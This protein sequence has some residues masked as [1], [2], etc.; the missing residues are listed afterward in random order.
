MGTQTRKKRE[1]E[2]RE[3]NILAVARESLIASGY[4]GLN[5]DAIASEL[6]YSK[7]TIYNHFNCKEEIII[8]LA[9]ETMEKRWEMFQRAAAYSG[10]PRERIAAVGVAAELFVRLYPSHFEVEQLI[11]A[12]SIWEK[13]SETRRQTMF[14][15]ES[16][17]MG[18]LAGVVRDGISQ[19]HLSLPDD[20]QPEDLVFGLWSQTFGAYSIIATSDDLSML[21]VGDPYSAVRINLNRM[22]DGYHWSPLSSD[23]NYVELAERLKGE[24]FPQECEHA[25]TV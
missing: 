8:A 6:D 13:T 21:G 2:E 17:C 11:R 7:G 3:A 4:R 20:F 22:L 24:I 1:L 16:R 18:L 19:G 12:T 9:I 10:L 14:A 15:C 25:F 23:Y 5:M